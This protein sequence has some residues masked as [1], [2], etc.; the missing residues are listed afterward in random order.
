MVVKCLEERATSKNLHIWANGRIKN[1]YVSSFVINWVVVVSNTQ[2][3]DAT[4]IIVL[5][6]KNKLFFYS[7]KGL[8]FIVKS[9]L[10]LS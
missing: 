7:F 8:D 10:V 3:L 2:G 9:L 5:F 1:I 4:Q 6:C